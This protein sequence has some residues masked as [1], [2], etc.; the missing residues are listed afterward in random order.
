MDLKIRRPRA[1]PCAK[2]VLAVF[3]SLFLITLLS[4]P[5]TTTSFETRQDQGSNLIFRTSYPRKGRMFLPAYLA[6]RARAGEEGRP[7]RLRAAQWIVPMAIVFVLGVVDYFFVCRLLWRPRQDG[8]EA[9]PEPQEGFGLD[10]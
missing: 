4:V 1:G 9:E 5:V 10:L 6:A 7:V 8:T 2:I 3:G